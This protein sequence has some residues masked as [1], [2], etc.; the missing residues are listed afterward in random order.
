MVARIG[1]SLQFA[2]DTDEFERF[3]TEVVK[4]VLEGKDSLEEDTDEPNDNA[5]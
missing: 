1:T 2:L 5:E 4:V 3:V